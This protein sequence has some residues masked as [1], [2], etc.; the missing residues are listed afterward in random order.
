MAKV[1]FNRGLYS[2][3]IVD[4]LKDGE[5]FF[6]TNTDT[7]AAAGNQ[8]IY[9]GVAQSDGTVKPV[10][11]A[12]GAKQYMTLIDN[13]FLRG[14]ELGSNIF[15][16]TDDTDTGLRFAPMVRTG[17][18]G[19]SLIAGV[20]GT[21]N[22]IFD[23]TKRAY[24]LAQIWGGESFGGKITLDGWSEGLKS[25]KSGEPPDIL[26]FFF[27]HG[28]D[29]TSERP[30]DNT[31]WDSIVGVYH[32]KGNYII[33]NENGD[34]TDVTGL[35]I[36]PAKTTNARVG[37]VINGKTN[38]DLL[39]ANGSTVSASGFLKNTA[40]AV[41]TA[42]LSDGAVT[43]AKIAQEAVTE[44]KIADGAVTK[45]KLATALQTTIDGAVQGNT[46]TPILK[47][48]DLTGTDAE[49]KAKLDQFEAD[50]KA[51]TGS[52]TLEG[53]RFVALS[54]YDD[55]TMQGMASYD[56]E[57]NAYRG[58]LG[59]AND[60][61][62]D[63]R[64]SCS[65]GSLTITPLFQHLEAVVLRIS[66]GDS[67]A[68]TVNAANK[69]SIENYVANLQS[70]GVSIEGTPCHFRLLKYKNGNYTNY[71]VNVGILK[72]TEKYGQYD[73][74]ID[75]VKGSV[76]YD[77]GKVTI[78]FNLNTI[79][80]AIRHG[81]EAITIYTDNTDEHMQANLDNIA[82]YE[83]N[84]QAL[85]VDTT[86]SPMI[87][88][89]FNEG[90]DSY[91]EYSGSGYISHNENYYSGYA[92]IGNGDAYTSIQ[93]NKELDDTSRNGTFKYQV[94]ASSLEVSSKVDKSLN[95]KSLEAVIIKTSN[96]DA[97]KAAN[98]AA[99]KAYVD[100]LKSLGV[101]VTNREFIIPFVIQEEDFSAAGYVINTYK[102]DGIYTG[103]YSDNE[104][105]IYRISIDP[106][107][108]IVY[109]YTLQQVSDSSLTTTSKQIVDA[110]NEVNAAVKTKASN[111]KDA[112][113]TGGINQAFDGGET[114]DVTSKNPNATALDSTIT[115]AL[116]RGA[117]GQYASSFGG[118]SIA[119]GKRSFAEGTT[120]IAK[121]NYSHAE[122]DNSVALGSDSHVEGYQT[123]TGPS[124][125]GAHA[126]GN[127]TQ[128]LGAASHSEGS[129]TIAKGNT[130]H[131]EGADTKANGVASHAE[132]NGTKGDGNYSHAEGNGTS[133]IGSSSHAE[134]YITIAQGDMS[135]AEG[136]LTKAIG[137]H[138]HTEGS[139]NTTNAGNS[140]A[141]GANNTVNNSKY[142]A[143][144]GGSSGSTGSTEPSE[145]ADFNIEE[146]YGEGGHAEG[147]YNNAYGYA[148]HAEGAHNKSK[149][150]YSHTEGQGNDAS[151]EG[152]HAEGWSTVAS[153]VHSHSEGQGTKAI[154]DNAHAE[155]NGSKATGSGS[156][157]E[158]S[159]T[160]QGDNAH[161]EGASIANNSNA[162]AEGLSTTASGNGAHSEGHYTQATN[163]AAHAEGVHTTANGD[164]S[165]TEGWY[166][167]AKNRAEHAEGFFNFS[168]SVS[169]SYYTEGNNT[170][171]S[172]GI[173]TSASDRK[174]ALEIMQNGDI[175]AYGVGGYDG[176]NA[177]N[178]ASKTLKTVIESK[179]DKLVSGTNIKTVNG[180]SLLGSG[181][182]TVSGGK[183]SVTIAIDNLLDTESFT[184]TAD[185]A[186]AFADPD[187]DIM[188]ESYNGMILPLH[189]YY[190]QPGDTTKVYARTYDGDILGVTGQGTDILMFMIDG[191]TLTIQNAI[192][193]YKLVLSTTQS[194]VALS[195][196]GD[197]LFTKLSTCDIHDI[198]ID[199][200]GLG[201]VYLPV[202]YR[203]KATDD[204]YTFV[205]HNYLDS[206]AGYAYHAIVMTKTS[207]NVTFEV[208]TVTN[209]LTDTE[210]ANIWDSVS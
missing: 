102:G 180:Q 196:G 189:I 25:I 192:L 45:G 165:H 201:F 131:A 150:H 200:G 210:I 161:A 164:G 30:G 137:S 101:D 80:K 106:V 65:S 134:G 168:N 54:L 41:G 119:M 151:G 82:A 103:V 42:N 199:V 58:I 89:V 23:T 27:P 160:A 110:I 177:V 31:V 48:I 205:Y 170:L 92:V 141:E 6:D 73:F 120:T 129:S 95:A 144:S 118:K 8:G 12:I 123:T 24:S 52:D 98:V 203:G 121:G 126:E 18:S 34:I 59:D 174:N 87:P 166:T 49:R 69:T 3:S 107:K 37:V 67:N 173:G 114:L 169:P 26:S 104:N 157:A 74:W 17:R 71:A 28:F 135:H 159:G 43:T 76:D 86:K 36:D 77:T 7:T 130:S 132:G 72:L 113:S 88:I 105:S 136:A 96:S 2:K 32:C 198:T 60:R 22:D 38:D 93:I 152:A 51:L 209:S 122:G 112:S 195:D 138:S 11:V 143:P 9:M 191:T 83:A 61:L 182:I 108:G 81:F 139:N 46:L 68:D 155:G 56:A 47:E 63:A 148:S 179:Q 78:S 94:L 140:H 206:T 55:T 33:S 172:V 162:H 117:T 125:M 133:A 44:S 147:M 188:I 149:A 109:S 85:G 19:F 202:L 145:P 171:H 16:Y 187:T 53:A 167:T 194:N 91:L 100:N 111:I 99:I 4:S 39:T 14:K 175:Y 1:K 178:N 142:T 75:G 190:M 154:G 57:F 186:A 50:W 153:G 79:L 183:K 156:H 10:K 62:L 207:D 158:G 21:D 181:D 66:D 15:M 84:L 70:L 146:H 204:E 184:L 176:T 97:D 13:T 185:Q 163:N 64:V 116:T 29:I 193:P 115:G 5:L 208:T 40:S 128:S 35:F 20:A 197:T 127:G 90:P 124:A